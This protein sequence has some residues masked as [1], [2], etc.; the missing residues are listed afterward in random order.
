MTHEMLE[1]IRVIVEVH[2]DL[3][4]HAMTSL[5]LVPPLV[6]VSNVTGS[7]VDAAMTPYFSVE[8]RQC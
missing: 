3:N 4:P 6:W 1:V 8:Q 7:Y 5:K 2:G